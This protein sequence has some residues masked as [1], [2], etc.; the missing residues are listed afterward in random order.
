M[1]RVSGPPLAMEAATQRYA[2]SSSVRGWSGRPRLAHVMA[3][4]HLQASHGAT[5]RCRLILRSAAQRAQRCPARSDNQ[6][7][8]PCAF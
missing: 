6:Q 4:D 1:G 8:L 3:E 2:D 5:R 7:S